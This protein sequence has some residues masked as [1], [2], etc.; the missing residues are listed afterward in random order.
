MEEL[1]AVE[2]SLDDWAGLTAS[3]LYYHR[4][5]LRLEAIDAVNYC[6]GRLDVS[7]KLT[8]LF[9]RYLD[10]YTEYIG[11]H[12]H[13]LIGGTID[14]DLLNDVFRAISIEL[15]EDEYD[16]IDPD[17]LLKIQIAIEG[18]HHYLVDHLDIYEILDSGVLS[19]RKS[20]DQLYIGTGRRDD[21]GG[22]N[23]L[24]HV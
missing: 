3:S 20:Y 8:D 14:T 7:Y 19:L 24:L 2:I 4:D 18:L 11:E 1:I 10:E 22:L 6:W 17:D 21:N 9:V 23:G 12:I 13:D 15:L 5:V 16:S